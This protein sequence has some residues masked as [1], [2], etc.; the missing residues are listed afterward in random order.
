MDLPDDPRVCARDLLHLRTA[1]HIAMDE[2]AIDAL[3]S[4]LAILRDSGHPETAVVEEAVRTHRIG[5]L[6]QRAIL[7][8][9]G[10]D[11]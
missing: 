5:I 6:K 11:V 1:L 7:G 3:A 2:A 10:L 9:A 4:A 8:A